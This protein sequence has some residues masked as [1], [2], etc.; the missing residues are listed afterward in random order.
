MHG[1]DK[2]WIVLGWFSLVAVA[3]AVGVGIWQTLWWLLLV[4]GVI[5][6]TVVT[7]LMHSH[8]GI[9]FDH[10][11]FSFWG[12]FRYVLLT[13]VVWAVVLLPFWSL[14]QTRFVIYVWLCLGS[15]ILRAIFF[16]AAVREKK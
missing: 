14:S 16:F 13:M 3:A 12:T 8:Y 9:K 4:L 6:A 11:G 1:G 7:A 15:L 5:V 10:W 2:F